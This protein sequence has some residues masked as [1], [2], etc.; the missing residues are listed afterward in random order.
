MLVGESGIDWKGQRKL[1]EVTGKEHEGTWGD[2]SDY[3]LLWVLVTQ[4][5]IHFS[6]F[7]NPNT[8]DLHISF[9]INYVSAIKK[10][11]K[12][13]FSVVSSTKFANV[14]TCPSLNQSLAREG[15]I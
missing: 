15:I 8:K 12:D 10:K 1:S 14:V 4:M 13:S 2:G 3:Y 9:N 7:F 11:Y 6:K 5:C